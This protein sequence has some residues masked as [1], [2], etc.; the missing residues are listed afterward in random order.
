MFYDACSSSVGHTAAVAVSTAA[1]ASSNATT[2]SSCCRGGT[3][4][5]TKAVTPSAAAQQ[6]TNSVS[7][8]SSSCAT[9]TTDPRVCLN[10]DRAHTGGCAFRS[11][12]TCVPCSPHARCPGGD[13]TWPVAGY[14]VSAESSPIAGKCPKPSKERCLGM[15]HTGRPDVTKQ[16]SA[17][18]R[19]ASC[20]LCQ[21]FYWASSVT[22]RCISC[23]NPGNT[24]E[25]GGVDMLEAVSPILALLGGLAFAFLLL[26][27]LIYV[28]QR[29]NGGTLHGGLSRAGH[30]ASYVIVLLQATL[31]VSNSATQEVVNEFSS[32]SG[33]MSVVSSA[34]ATGSNTTG[35]V[36]KTGAGAMKAGRAEAELVASIFEAANVFQLDFSSTVKLECFNA[37]PMLFE[38]MYLGFMFCL[39]LT[40]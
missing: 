13:R 24:T 12:D 21:E 19:G 2:V 31:Y 32:D 16:C 28:M 8:G 6:D 37:P 7:G 36:N 35:G 17:A 34:G 11:G 4:L 20:E 22:G 25:A 9:F 23:G 33:S 26:A 1:T 18:Y 38:K 10:A 40:W 27:A 5:N 15:T 39:V 3:V 14:W 30:F 29:R